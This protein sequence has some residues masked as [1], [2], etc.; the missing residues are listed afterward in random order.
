[1][2]KVCFVKTAN[3]KKVSTLSI[4]SSIISHI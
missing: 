2:S 3:F 1:L 4:L